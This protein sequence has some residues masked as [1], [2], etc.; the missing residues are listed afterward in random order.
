LEL[1]QPYGKRTPLIFRVNFL[2]RDVKKKKK[3][4]AEHFPSL[5]DPLH[6]ALFL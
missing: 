2:S 3:R 4:A 6:V 1:R 5:I